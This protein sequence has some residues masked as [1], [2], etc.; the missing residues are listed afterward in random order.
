MASGE[1]LQFQFLHHESTTLKK[2]NQLRMERRFCDVTIVTEQVRFSGHRVVLAA[3]S[4]FLRDQFLLNPSKEVQVALSESAEMMSRLLLSCYTG[5]LHFPFKE[6]VN[7][8]TT[9]SYLQMDHVVEECRRALSRYI[10][11]RIKIK[12]DGG[13]PEVRTQ[14]QIQ[15]QA[16]IQARAQREAE[17]KSE[18]EDNEE[19]DD[20]YVIIDT[21]SPAAEPSGSQQP[22]YPDLSEATDEEEGCMLISGAYPEDEDSSASEECRAAF[23]IRPRTPP[24]T[25]V[26]PAAPCPQPIHCS[27]CAQAFQ[28]PEHLVAH[29]KAHK[30]FMCPRCGKVFSQRVNLARHIHVH[31]GIKPYLCTV[32]GKTFTQNR[33]LKDHMNLHSGAR[34]HHCHYCN[35]S[36]AHKPALRRHLKEQH[37]KTTADN[38]K[39]AELGH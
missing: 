34:P 32:C 13:G 25:R 12:E 35:M 14:A 10:D 4:P 3:C 23:P 20:V 39:L 21:D 18:S 27:E 16:Q 9:A 2:M 22:A 29:M 31:T 26:N 37:G 30:L 15:S 7:Y 24:S 33:S 17:V 36:F 38:C 5:V 28:H 19:A 6:V 8:L 11:P 1:V